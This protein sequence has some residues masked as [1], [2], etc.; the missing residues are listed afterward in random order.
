MGGLT[1]LILLAPFIVLAIDEFHPGF[2]DVCMDIVKGGK[3]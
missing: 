1:L 3:R 2:L